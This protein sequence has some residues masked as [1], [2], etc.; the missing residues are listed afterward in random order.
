M[1][2]LNSSFIPYFR[3]LTK[4]QLEKIECIT[5]EY[6]CN[7][8]DLVF[9]QG[10]YCKSLIIVNKGSFLSRIKNN[11]EI[12]S[13]NI[14][15]EGE[16]YD[17]ESIIKNSITSSTF[18]SIGKSSFFVIDI[19][20][21]KKLSQKN[22]IITSLIKLQLQNNILDLWDEYILKKSNKIKELR[23]VFTRSFLWS[24][25]RFIPVVLLL[26]VLLFLVINKIDLKR[27]HLVLFVYFSINLFLYLAIYLNS[28]L[29]RIDIN[30]EVIV[31]K[32]FTLSN[33]S[34]E[35]TSIPIEKIQ[36]VKT[37]FSKRFLRI[38]SL[39]TIEV[40]SASE[41]LQLDGVFNPKEKNR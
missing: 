28:K 1:A 22:P 19:L 21:L 37:L 18:E 40:E 9:L 33:V 24:I 38:I 12:K 11:N 7:D 30:R 31:K 14:Y 25:I 15:L 27:Q 34:K 10:E 17:F 35:Y 16:I 41:K 20:A 39:G 29:T 26:T 6:E 32:C 36:S 2:D 4:N 13:E 3:E 5:R 8:G 23:V